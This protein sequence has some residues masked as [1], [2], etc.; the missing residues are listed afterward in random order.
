M[1]KELK[2]YMGT[3]SGQLKHDHD[4]ALRA[5]EHFKEQLDQVQFMGYG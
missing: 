2:S 4:E 3:E 1:Q 5:K